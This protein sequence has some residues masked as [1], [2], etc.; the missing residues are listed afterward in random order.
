M[1]GGASKSFLNAAALFIEMSLSS[2]LLFKDSLI[3]FLLYCK[4]RHRFSEIEVLGS[5]ECA[6][7]SAPVDMKKILPAVRIFVVFSSRCSSGAKPL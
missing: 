6:C 2:S 3:M 4:V 5:I 1:V 7:L